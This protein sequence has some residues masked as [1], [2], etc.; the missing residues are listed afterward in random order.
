MTDSALMM[1][2]M[3]PAHLPSFIPGPDGSDGMFT[4]LS[5]LVIVAVFVAG[6]LYFKLHSLPEHMAAGVGRAQYQLVGIL[7]LVALF[8]HENIFWIAALI[9]AVVQIPD[10]MTPLSS[11]AGSLR[12][13][14]NEVVANQAPAAVP[15]DEEGRRND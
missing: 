1:H 9:L 12:V 6:A 8:T 5:I 14:S 4:N 15:V 11:I 2:Q 7:A 13:I 10:I 3:A